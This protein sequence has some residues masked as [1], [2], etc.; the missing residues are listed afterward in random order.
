MPPAT[1]PYQSSVSAA[2]EKDCYRQKELIN[3]RLIEEQI[4]KI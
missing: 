2:A 3:V 4:K 1:G